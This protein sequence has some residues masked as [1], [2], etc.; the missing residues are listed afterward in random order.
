MGK[1]HEI[2]GGEK[3]YKLEILM[4]NEAWHY[5]TKTKI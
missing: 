4:I 5:A 3:L 1:D 2:Q